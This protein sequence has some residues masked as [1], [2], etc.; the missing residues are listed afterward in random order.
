[1]RRLTRNPEFVFLLIQVFIFVMF[2]AMWG[3]W[4][5][6]VEP[7]QAAAWES[8]RINTG[9]F[10]TEWGIFALSYYL[11][12]PKLFEAGK[13]RTI[14]RWIFW[15]V[16]MLVIVQT[17]TVTTKVDGKQVVWNEATRINVYA[18]VV[19]K[20]TMGFA[21]VGLAIGRRIYLHQQHI[22]QQL[23]A[24]AAQK[25]EAEL[26]WLKNQ[27]HPHFLFNTLNNISSLILIDG[28]TAVEKIAQLSDLLR[29]ALYE[30]KEEYVPLGNEVEFMGN[31]ISLM[32]LRCDEHVDVK[33]DFEVEDHTYRLAP[34]LFLSPIE[35]AFRHGMSID[36][37]SF[38]HIRLTERDN[39]VIFECRNSNYPKTDRRSGSGIGKE[40]MTRRLELLYPDCH[41]LQQG[42]DGDVYIVK[43][44]LWTI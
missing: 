35:N 2:V 44:E 18:M 20:I 16:T 12:V 28:F 26:H 31:Y 32:R 10:L 15:M 22:K 23:A 24:M 41:T 43:V 6:R 36:Q 13:H 42:L 8:L 30:T 40:N 19:A 39:R 11:L 27:L 17:S 5:F 3:F 14:K 25:A 29:Y 9:T 38:I 1:M 7:N 37:P 21:M 4:V 34:L 33:V